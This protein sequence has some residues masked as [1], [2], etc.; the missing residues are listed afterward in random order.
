MDGAMILMRLIFDG[1]E[2]GFVLLQIRSLLSG[3]NGGCCVVFFRLHAFAEKVGFDNTKV[4]AVRIG[5]RYRQAPPYRCPLNLLPSRIKFASKGYVFISLQLAHKCLW[6][7][8][9]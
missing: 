4:S 7:I 5:G 1:V 3:A 6:I 8:Q 2:I 9:I